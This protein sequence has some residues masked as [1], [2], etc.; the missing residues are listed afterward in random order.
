MPRKV[1]LLSIPHFRI[2]EQAI[3]TAKK[4]YNFQFLI[5]GYKRTVY[6][7]CPNCLSFQFLILGYKPNK[8]RV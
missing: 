8:L 7:K 4:W 3:Q 1:K 5:L 2:P 6:I